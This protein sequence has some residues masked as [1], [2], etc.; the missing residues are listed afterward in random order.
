MKLKVVFVEVLE[1]NTA[2]SSIS[3]WRFVESV[4]D[5]VEDTSLP[6]AALLLVLESFS[7]SYQPRNFLPLATLDTES[8]TV[9]P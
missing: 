9:L 2:T 5:A 1:P 3:L 4:N 8:A 6:Y 7:F